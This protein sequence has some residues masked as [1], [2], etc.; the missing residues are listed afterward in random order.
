MGVRLRT[1]LFPRRRSG[2]A[3]PPLRPGAALLLLAMAAAGCWDRADPDTTVRLRSGPVVP[4]SGGTP[5]DGSAPPPIRFVYAS[6]LSPERSTLTYARLGAYLSQR[7]GRPV[8]IVRRRTYAELNEL[9]QSGKAEA[10]LVCT[11]AFA[12]AGGGRGLVALAIP[13][14]RGSTTYRSYVI[15]RRDSGLESFDDLRGRVF[16]FS[17]PLSN[18]GYRYVAARL[19]DAGTDPDAFFSRFLFTFSHD[20]S[21][22][23]VLDGIADAA[24][25][26][27]LVWDEL[28]QRDPTLERDLVIVDRSEPFPINPVAAGTGAR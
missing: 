21:I 6:V 22:E 26:D 10:G 9:L 15:A 12:A 20:N 2:G 27:S 1:V 25:V 14:I 19:R 3:A 5:V 13:V 7:L 8:E 17:D 16:A 4:S 23:A 24:S 18:T 28:I 11:G